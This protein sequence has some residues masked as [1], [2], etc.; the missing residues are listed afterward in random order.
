MNKFTEGPW[1]QL[2]KDPLK[3][4][5][6]DKLSIACIVSQAGKNGRSYEEKLANARLISAAPEMLEALHIARMQISYDLKT[7][8][9]QP[10]EKEA[11]RLILE[12]VEKAITRATGEFFE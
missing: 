5:G 2:P 11:N 12:V 1:K 3:I 10:T 9:Q 7:R 6:T 4:K 8:V